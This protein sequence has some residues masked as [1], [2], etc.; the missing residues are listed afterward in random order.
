MDKDILYKFFDGTASLE[1]EMA[2]REWMEKSENNL[3]SFFKERML[4][5]AMIL[6]INKRTVEKTRHFQFIS[7]KNIFVKIAAA[8]AI[9]ITVGFFVRNYDIIGKDSIYTAINSVFVPAGQRAKLIL[10]DGSIVWLNSQ[11][12]FQYPSVFAKNIREVKLDGEAYFEVK[13]NKKCPFNVLTSKGNVR[14]TGTK[15]NVMA[16]S[17][18]ESFE[19][20]LMEG[21]VE[22]LPKNASGEI[23]VLKPNQKSTLKNNVLVVEPISDSNEYLWRDGLIAFKDKPFMDILSKFEKSFGVKIIVIDDNDYIL[24][25]TYTGKFRVSDGVDY[26]LGVLQKSIH[27]EYNRDDEKQIIYIK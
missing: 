17:S 14:V 24:K 19:T 22:I 20:A 25:N 6:N 2:V 18:H 4:F 3:K 5:D 15:F 23:V 27:F 9:I 13:A 26:S 1:E 21:R 12:F 16:Y 10:S 8:I 11:T 7:A